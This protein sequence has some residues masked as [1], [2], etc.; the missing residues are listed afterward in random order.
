MTLSKRSKTK[1]SQDVERALAQ[2]QERLA[3]MLALSSDWYWEQ[4]ENCRFTV[5]VGT[6]AQQTEG[7]L[8]PY[9]GTARW[10]RGAV[11]VE[12]GGSWDKHKAVLEARQ[13]F[14]DFVFKRANARGELRYISTTGEPVFDAEKR[15][16]GYRGTARDITA[17]VRAE[18]EQRRQSALIAQ[19]AGND[20]LL[21]LFYEL[22]F[23]GLA[24]TSPSSKRW[25]QVNDY[26]CEMLGYSREELL[27]L[28][29]TET[30]HP[31]DLPA[32]LSLFKRLSAGEFDSFQLEKRFVR[33][34]GGFVD[35]TMEVSCGRRADGSVETVIIMVR[36]ITERKRA[37]ELQNLEHAVAH[38]I[39]AAEDVTVTMTAIIRAICEAQSWECGRYLRVDEKVG[40]L[41]L[42]ASWGVPEPAI[43][44]YIER[45]GRLSREGVYKP[46][47][48]LIGQVWQSGQP[49]WIADI[50][51][52]P[53]VLRTA[54]TADDGIRGGFVFP[55]ISG[56]KAIG[57][58][59]FNS[60]QVREPDERLLK[61]ILAMGSQIG[62]FLERKR[63]EEEQRRFR[64]ATDASADLM[65]LIDPAS[66]RYI[67][68]NDAACRALGYSREELLTMGPPDI[69]SASREK[70]T[71]LYEQMIS[72]ELIAPDV[73]GHY[74]RKDGSK[75]P[76][77]AYPRAVRSGEGH[78]I[79]SIA[80]DIS[81]RI[82][83]EEALR[84]SE[85]RFR[86]LT[87]LSSDLYWE[88]DDQYRF[89]SFSGTGPAGAKELGFDLV[90]KTRWEQGYLNMSAVD[91]SE[92]MAILD[93]R[94]PFHD[95]E[96]CRLNESGKQIWI[97][98]RGEPVFDASGVFKG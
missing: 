38:R 90:G 41:R 7:E 27:E 30:T 8:K 22:P 83:A 61:A 10:D 87:Q 19:S 48:G 44:Q 94:Q 12:D 36:D 2:C 78:V 97:G 5:V 33:K 72:G 82:A 67:D 60:R 51:K 3:R 95:L 17:R 47:V 37:E 25:L 76:I 39:A 42:D 11:P 59:A 16:N 93:A 58:L 34:D 45:S 14:T 53:R 62:Q 46:G 13:P 89:T 29:W 74:R 50:T 75:L 56:G 81:E 57:V 92:H 79:V 28:A 84:A 15:F 4:D 18:E 21:R 55:I 52:D 64:V 40:A 65:L 69:F 23:V 88:Q 54:F 26:M 49:L 77:E 85:E 71:Q 9:L 63:A 96:L 35:T 32:N 86:S 66:L 73:K 91:W 20:R 98:V 1:A 6:G 68:V 31:D 80:R 24:V 43:R 70:L